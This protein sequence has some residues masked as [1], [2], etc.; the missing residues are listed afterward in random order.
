MG[1][2]LNKDDDD[3]DEVEI[4]RNLV[5]QWEWDNCLKSRGVHFISVCKERDKG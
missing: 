3:N 1:Y 5:S 2:Q 4:V